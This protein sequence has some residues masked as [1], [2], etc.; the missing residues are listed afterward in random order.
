MKFFV[1]RHKFKDFLETG[2]HAQM[3]FTNK[4]TKNVF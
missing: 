2:V 1:S 4:V 3:A